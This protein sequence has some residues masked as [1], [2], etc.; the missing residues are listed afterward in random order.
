MFGFGYSVQSDY[1]KGIIDMNKLIAVNVRMSEG[2]NTKFN[3]V[4]ATKEIDKS[5]DDAINLFFKPSEKCRSI[6]YVEDAL[7]TRDYINR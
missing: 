1:K 5:I 4:E 2:K 6:E 3:R 7:F